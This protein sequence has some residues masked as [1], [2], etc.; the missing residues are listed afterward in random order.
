MGRFYD[1]RSNPS[2]TITNRGLSD[3]YDCVHT[4]VVLNKTQLL[5]A[6]RA[7]GV[8]NAQIQ[9]VLD[10]PSSRV[11]EI[12]RASTGSDL[13]PR[14][15][16]YDEGVKLAQAFLPELAQLADVPPLQMLRLAVLHLARRLGVQLRE[17]QLDGLARDLRAFLRYA[18]SPTARGSLEAAESFFAALDHLHQPDPGEEAPPE[19]GRAPKR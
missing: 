2:T 11:S 10:L 3:R 18:A 19:N 9:E 16:T 14:D 15:L 8:K 6:L 1:V 4:I 12:F 13:K 7:K 5:A 17:P